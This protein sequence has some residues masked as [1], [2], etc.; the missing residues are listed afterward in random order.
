VADRIREITG[1]SRI[2]VGVISHLHLDHMGYSGYG[3]F[4]HLIEEENIVFGKIIDRD[5]GSWVDSN[6]DKV[7]N[8]DTEINW[9]NVGTF[10]GTATNWLCYA[11]NPANKKIYNIRE[12]AQLCSTTQINPPDQDSF[13]QIITVDG[14]GAYMKDGKTPITGDYSAWSVPPSENDF[15]VGLLVGF[16]DLRYVTMGDLDGDYAESSYGYTYNNIEATV[17]PRV[18]KVD[19]YHVNHHG[20]GHSSSSTLLS[21]LRPTV[22][23]ISC[24]VDNSYGHP[25]QEVLDR[26]LDYG[27]VFLTSDCDTS[28]DYYSAQRLNKDI[29]LSSSDGKAFSV[30][31]VKGDVNF[32]ASPKSSQNNC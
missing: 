23:L 30:S 25:E 31:G 2:D 17:A 5:A 14:I 11:T 3:G 13:V 18:G 24:G 19:V 27:S 16:G 10:S 29:R 4:W 15:S 1:G 7:C 28:R 9:N 32:Q 12:I 6:G 8:P 21:T 20:S 22:S 26:L